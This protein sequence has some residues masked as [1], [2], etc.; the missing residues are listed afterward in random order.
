[1]RNTTVASAMHVEKEKI[2]ATRIVVPLVSLPLCFLL[3]S[4]M[5]ASSTLLATTHAPL[6]PGCGSNW[7]AYHT[8]AAQPI[9]GRCVCETRRSRQLCTSRKKTRYTAVE[10]KASNFFSSSSCTPHS[11]TMARPPTVTT[12]TNIPIHLIFIHSLISSTSLLRVHQ[13]CEPRSESSRH[14]LLLM[15]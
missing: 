7:Y 10:A 15:S 1:M 11:R 4:P 2:H 13:C 6:L 5:L 14:H 3:A 12:T 9:H 8:E